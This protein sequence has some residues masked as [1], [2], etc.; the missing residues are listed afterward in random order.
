MTWR[1]ANGTTCEHFLSIHGALMQWAFDDHPSFIPR[2]STVP[3]PALTLMYPV[4]IDQASSSSLLVVAEPLAEPDHPYL[5]ASYHSFIL[6]F[7]F[8]AAM[9]VD[10]F[11]NTQNLLL[12]DGPTIASL[13]AKNAHIAESNFSTGCSSARDVLTRSTSACFKALKRSSSH[14]FIKTWQSVQ[15]RFRR[16]MHLWNS[17]QRAYFGALQF[18]RRTWRSA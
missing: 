16:Q 12:A 14:S 7:P 18:S 5:P 10:A 6:L 3:S 9:E 11:D 17:L 15:G 8:P 1:Q 4:A 13:S 2:V